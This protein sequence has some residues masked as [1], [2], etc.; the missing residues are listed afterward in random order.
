[1]YQGAFLFGMGLSSLNGMPGF[2]GTGPAMAAV[3]NYLQSLSKEV[4]DK[5]VFVGIINLGVIILGSKFS[6]TFGNPM[7]GKE[8]HADELAA[9]LYQQYTERKELEL[10][11]K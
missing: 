11:F 3:R 5:G 4:G 10:I 2:S 9:S 6:D 8:I 1:M 7:K